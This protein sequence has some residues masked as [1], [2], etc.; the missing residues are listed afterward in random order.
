M[1]WERDEVMNLL[2]FLIERDD[3]L[4][5]FARG[6]QLETIQLGQ[7]PFQSIDHQYRPFL[8]LSGD[9]VGK[10]LVHAEIGV[11]Q[12]KILET[13]TCP[14]FYGLMDGFIQGIAME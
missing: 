6:Q 4:Y 9:Q 5:D 10:L 2:Y 13:L 12:V 8:R 1:E 3:P 11:E 7:D 14:F